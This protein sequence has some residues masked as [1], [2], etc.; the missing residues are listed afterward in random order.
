MAKQLDFL[1][2]STLQIR[3]QIRNI[4]DSYNHDWDLLAELAQNA[5]DAITLARS[6]GGY[7]TLEIDACDKRIVLE[8]NGCG[9]SPSELP[10]LLAPFST[11]KLGHD[12]LIGN[13]GVGIRSCTHKV[14]H[15]LRRCDSSSQPQGAWR[16]AATI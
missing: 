14:F 15:D 11:G 12:D 6:T 13:K 10:E 8:D 16:W 7:L 3:H 2:P 4:V 5:V 9:I 1:K